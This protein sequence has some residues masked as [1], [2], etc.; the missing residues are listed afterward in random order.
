MND[1]A[2]F[3]V[4][5]DGRLMAGSAKED[6]IAG[7]AK[8]FKLPEEKAAEL[9]DG[10]TRPIK[11]KVDQP[12]G[13]KYVAAMRKVGAMCRLTP[14]GQKPPQAA[15]APPAPVSEQ[16]APAANAESAPAAAVPAAAPATVDEDGDLSLAPVG[17]TIDSLPRFDE[18]VDVESLDLNFDIAAAGSDMLAEEFKPDEVHSEPDT[19]GISVTEGEFD[20]R[21]GQ[22]EKDIPAPPDTSEIKLED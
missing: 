20:L 5:F 15:K 2:L 9:F 12:T 4:M 22:P 16:V 14:H 8:L 3:D 21:E 13:L 1:Q 7:V 19:S 18:V 11:S 6:V 17:Q 10:K